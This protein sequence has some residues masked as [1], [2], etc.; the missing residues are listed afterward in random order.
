MASCGEKYV[1]GRMLIP[2]E[3]RANGGL[4][5]GVPVPSPE[6]CAGT[7]ADVH[8]TPA[9]TSVSYV[10]V[11]CRIHEVREAEKR[12]FSTRV[13]LGEGERGI[14]NSI[15]SVPSASRMRA[16]GWVIVQRMFL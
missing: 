10:I 2:R 16:L 5:A 6:S 8:A 7:Y 4:C 11:L 13:A 14:H 1:S 12:L 3:P 9:R 15:S